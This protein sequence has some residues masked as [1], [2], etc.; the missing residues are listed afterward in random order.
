[1]LYGIICR[2]TIDDHGYLLN[3]LP[4]PLI[5]PRLFLGVDDGWIGGA[6]FVDGEL[7]MM[8]DVMQYNAMDGI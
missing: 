4:M 5:L 6:L 8:D 1:M 2:V 7:W 3:R